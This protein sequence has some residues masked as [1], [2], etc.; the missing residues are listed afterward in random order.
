MT[1]LYKAC[2][3]HCLVG[4]AVMS[5]GATPAV[6]AQ[7]VAVPTP[8]S[9]STA[10]TIEDPML[11]PIADARRSI[12]SWQEARRQLSAT[13][14]DVRKA[15]ADVARAEALSRQA[16]SLLLPNA[17][18]SAAVA[19]DLD[20]PDTAPGV[21]PLV[22]DRAATTPVATASILVTQSLIDVASWR[23]RDAAESGRE[24]SRWALLDVHRRINQNLARTLIAVVA[25]ERIAEL[26]R[27]GLRQSLERAQLSQRTFELGRAT[28]LDVVRARQDVAQARS[29]LVV[30]DEQLRSAREA[31]GLALGIDDQVGV[32]NEFALDGLIAEVQTQCRIL[33]S[34]E[35]R[36]DEEAA[37]AAL[38]A[39][40][41]RSAQAR[42]SKLPTLE[43]VSNLSALTTDP[44][45]GR[46]S[47][48]SISAVLSIPLWEGGVRSAQVKERAA[49]ET[50]AAAS[51]EETRRLTRFERAR[52]SRGQSVAEVLVT[53]AT[54]ARTLAQR[55]DVMT[56][57]SFEIGR[58]TSLDLVQSAVVLRA[59]ELDLALRQ[60]EAVQAR[61][62]AFLTEARCDS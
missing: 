9:S 36:S 25:A 14:I 52:A 28:E 4:V 5:G 32:S 7:P 13:S 39:A 43:F 51:V 26:G 62:D 22:D 58:A 21:P 55:L 16:L 53:V 12:R 30:S 54:E 24:S 61:L 42:A 27:V 1:A 35:T 20:R 6:F 34:G 17:F 46:V 49:L 44:G 60:F 8:A 3:R 19:Y 48:W 56:R 10:S 31:L 38:T 29:A 50:D 41:S 47:S 18:A 15:E 37:M 23:G 57:R 45:P 59:A 33:A 40:R 11:A 2:C